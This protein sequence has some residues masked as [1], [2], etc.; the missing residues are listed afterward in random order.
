[1]MDWHVFNED[2][3]N[4]NAYVSLYKKQK[5]K[6]SFIIIFTSFQL[7]LWPVFIALLA[8]HEKTIPLR[9]NL[10]WAMHS[11]TVCRVLPT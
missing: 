7:M 6:V 3:N 11:S 5:S 8:K 9:Q 4:L 2:I 1:M 10:C